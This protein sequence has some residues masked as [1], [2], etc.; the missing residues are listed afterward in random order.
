MMVGSGKIQK[1]YTVWCGYCSQWEP[2][3]ILDGTKVEVAGTLK[4][5]GWKLVKGKWMCPDC[6]AEKP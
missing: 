5:H 4:R 6:L 2:N 3:D 1:Y